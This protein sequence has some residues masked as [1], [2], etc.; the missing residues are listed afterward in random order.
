M[1]DNDEVGWKR[2]SKYMK[3]F[4]GLLYSEQCCHLIRFFSNKTFDIYTYIP[5]I[6]IKMEFL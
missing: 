5:Y 1:K 3:F 6:P 2:I 4:A